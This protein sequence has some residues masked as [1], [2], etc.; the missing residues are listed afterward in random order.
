MNVLCLGNNLLHMSILCIYIKCIELSVASELISC[1]ECG[2]TAT[3]ITNIV[4]S[5]FMRCHIPLILKRATTRTAL[6]RPS[7][8]QL[9]IRN[10]I[11]SEIKMYCTYIF[12]LIIK[13]QVKSAV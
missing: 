9:K 12:I 1:R 6:I 13:D 8:L 3:E 5:L 4:V 11:H 7:Q 10:T 2:P